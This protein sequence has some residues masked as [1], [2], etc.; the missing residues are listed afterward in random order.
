MNDGPDL[1]AK[2]LAALRAQ[3]HVRFRLIHIDSG[4][5]DGT[6]DVI[7]EQGGDLY[8]IRPGE[9]IPGQALNFGMELCDDDLATFLNAD[10]V[11]VGRDWLRRLLEALAGEA[12]AVA[13]FSRQ[14][15]RDDAEPLVRK[16]HARAYGDGS[17]QA[18]WPHFFSMAASAIR[19]SYWREHRFDGSLRYSEDLDWTYRA[20]LAGREV[21]YVP[22]SVAVHSHNYSLGQTWR[23]QQGEGEADAWI[24][25]LS[26]WKASF[27]RQALLPFVAETARDVRYALSDGYLGAAVAAPLVRAAQKL[28]RWN[29][30]RR[31]LATASRSTRFLPPDVSAPTRGLYTETADREFEARLD[32]DFRRIAEALLTLS[33]K[34]QAVI[35]G[36]GYGRREGGLLAKEGKSAPYNDYDIYAV[37]D[38]VAARLPR[39]T[40]DTVAGLAHALTSEM[41]VDVDIAAVSRRKLEQASPRIEWYELRRGHQ[42]LYGPPRFLDLMPDYRGRDIPYDEGERLLMNRGVGMILARRRLAPLL[43]SG[44]AV[45]EKDLDFI[46]RNIYKALLAA[47]DA[48]LLR[49]GLYHYSYRERLARLAALKVDSPPRAA[50]IKH[51]YAEAMRFRATPIFRRTTAGELADFWREAQ[52]LFG[53]AQ[54]WF[55]QATLGVADWDGYAARMLAAPAAPFEAARDAWRAW[56]VLGPKPRGKAAMRDWLVHPQRR[57][58]AAAPYLLH[59]V[60]IDGAPDWP[61]GAERLADLLLMD[62]PDDGGSPAVRLAELEERCLDLWR[63]SN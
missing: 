54:R 16:D 37:F 35:L 60:S 14:I 45:G 18:E 9:Y 6:L 55:Y 17:V 58:R 7:R 63:E 46:T 30:I 62:K 33:P 52:A 38:A 34:P 25:R 13:A 2:T 20:K 39:Q 26:P 28:G 47:G 27:A 48:I 49:F 11:P 15:P 29:G 41:E 61:D 36:G 22:D 40:T 1:V 19:R 12:N 51:A 24:F 56:R 42:V 59:Y 5:T 4:S 31:G 23:R 32:A 44:D 43:A 53:E 57:V 8:H 21:I 50:E 10:A 3:E